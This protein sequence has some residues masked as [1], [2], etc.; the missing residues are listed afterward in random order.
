[1]IIAFWNVRGIANPLK[2]CKIKNTLSELRPDWFSIQE[3]KLNDVDSSCIAQLTG[4]QDV[5]FTCFPAINTA[6]G[7]ICCWNLA[8]F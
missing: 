7:I 4:W 5:G 8:S 1:M 3:S 2:R 6:E